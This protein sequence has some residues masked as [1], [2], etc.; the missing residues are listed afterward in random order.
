MSVGSSRVGAVIYP[1]C[2]RGRSRW[3]GLHV[4]GRQC[5]SGDRATRRRAPCPATGFT[6]CVPRVPSDVERPSNPLLDCRWVNWW[7]RF[8]DISTARLRA[9][10]PLGYQVV[11]WCRL[12][13]ESAGR[14][15]VAHPAAR[16]GRARGLR[17][18]RCFGIRRA[19][20]FRVGVVRRPRARRAAERRRRLAGR[21]RCSQTLTQRSASS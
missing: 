5:R 19:F 3:L 12:S 4:E 11:Y 20:P 13:R 15:C 14:G 17:R 7:Q 18:V 21:G 10:R 6:A 16:D 8:G 1:F 2:T 9:R